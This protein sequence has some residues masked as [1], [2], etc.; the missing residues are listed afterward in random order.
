MYFGK[1][2]DN[3]IALAFC[4]RHHGSYK[5]AIFLGAVSQFGISRQ[6]AER[7]PLATCQ[8]GIDCLHVRAHQPVPY[9]SGT[10]AVVSG[11]A[12]NGGPAGRR[13]IDR[14]E[15]AMRPELGIQLV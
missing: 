3:F 14:E 5:T 6:R 1:A 13:H 8:Q 9:G 11:H 4:E 12:A 7:R 2:T 15:Q 10:A